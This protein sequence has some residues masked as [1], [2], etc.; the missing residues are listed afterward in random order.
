MD[1]YEITLAREAGLTVCTKTDGTPDL[2]EDGSPQ[3][4][5]TSQQ[6]QE[7]ARLSETA[8]RTMRFYRPYQ[9]EKDEIF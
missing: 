8:E 3:F 5:G 1:D 2:D 7:F 9:L 6:W 4:I